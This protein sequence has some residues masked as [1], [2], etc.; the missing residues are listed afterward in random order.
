[1]KKL[2]AGLFIFTFCVNFVFGAGTE[3]L[4]FY[5][6]GLDYYKMGLYEESIDLFRKSIEVDPEFIDGYF[7]LGSVYEYLHRYDEALSVF[8]QIVVRNPEDYDAVYH[9]AWLSFKLGEPDKAKKF[10]SLIPQ[11]T[12]RAIDAEELYAKMGMTPV[13][14]TPSVQK[15]KPKGKDNDI[16]EGIIS[17]TG[18]A[19]DENNNLYVAQFNSNS[20]LKITPEGKK[21]LF[22]KNSKINGPICIAFDM[23]DNLYI[24]NYNADNIL[25]VTS[26]GT[27]SIL[28]SNVKKPYGLIVNDGTL[29]VSLQGSNNVVK[30]KLKY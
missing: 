14:K 11:N 7:N 25:K 5:N 19:V 24:A 1:M 28:I 23:Y 9:A 10:L 29:Y 12:A 4:L 6:K 26:G 18:L 16:F 8:K 21:I 30:Y 13:F 27:V 17:P 15:E 20:I 2:F 3:A 22:L